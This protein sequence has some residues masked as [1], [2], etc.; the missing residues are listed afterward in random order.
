MFNGMVPL[1]VMVTAAG[2]ELVP[3]VVAP[4]VRLTGET[5]AIEAPL[6]PVSEIVCWLPLT[7]PESSVTT[8]LPE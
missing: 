6:E 1:L 2:E 7:A 5:L 3:T 4:N 8:T